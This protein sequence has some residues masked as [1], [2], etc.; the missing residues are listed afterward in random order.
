MGHEYSLI[1]LI[2]IAGLLTAAIGLKKLLP[3]A[4]E[5]GKV[6]IPGF[7]LT[8]FGALLMAAAVGLLAAV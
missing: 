2:F 1:A 7:C 5:S 8:V 3:V 4:N 6:I